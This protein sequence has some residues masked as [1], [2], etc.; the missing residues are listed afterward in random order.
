LEP[1]R[2]IETDFRELIKLIDKD[3]DGRVTISDFCTFL[4]PRREQMIDN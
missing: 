4:E 1:D 2:F 3:G